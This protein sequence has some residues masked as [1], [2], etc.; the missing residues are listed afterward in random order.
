MHGLWS[1]ANPAAVDPPQNADLVNLTCMKIVDR[2]VLSAG[3]FRVASATTGAR[4][5]STRAEATRRAP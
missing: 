1:R 2:L 3:T 5:A 4:C